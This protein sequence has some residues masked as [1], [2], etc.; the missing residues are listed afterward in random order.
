MS[1]VEGEAGNIVLFDYSAYN[2]N[3][4]EIALNTPDAKEKRELIDAKHTRSVCC[5]M[6]SAA[7]ESTLGR[8]IY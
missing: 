6:L 5:V 4:E 3:Y 7:S 2:V 8:W 1:A